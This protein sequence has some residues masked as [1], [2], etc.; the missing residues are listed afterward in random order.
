MATHIRTSG[1]TPRHHRQVTYTE[2]A[3]KEI[4][5]AHEFVI[6]TMRGCIHCAHIK[7]CLTGYR[8]FE[9]DWSTSPTAVRKLLRGNMIFPQLFYKG[10]RSK[11]WRTTLRKLGLYAEFQA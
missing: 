1:G 7:Q 3:L 10:N 11:N 2:K 9:I 8:Y 6:I 5:Q 4:I